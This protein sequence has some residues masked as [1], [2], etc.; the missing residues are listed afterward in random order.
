MN[1]YPA[2]AHQ[3]LSFF[4]YK[5]L[6][7]KLL[8]LDL[9]ST[10]VFNILLEALSR[11]NAKKVAVRLHGYGKMFILFILQMQYNWND[12]MAAVAFGCGVLVFFV[13]AKALIRQDGLILN[14]L[15]LIAE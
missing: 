8:V 10:W 9:S 11:Y 4:F 6:H 5:V 1:I 3:Y 14:N 12:W 15:D 2:P 7:Q 13:V